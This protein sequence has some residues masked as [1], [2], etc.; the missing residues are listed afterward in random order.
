MG[1]PGVLDVVVW[2]VE[3]IRRAE[4]SDE[5][6]VPITSW[7]GMKPGEGGRMKCSSTTPVEPLWPTVHHREFRPTRSKTLLLPLHAHQMGSGQFSSMHVF[8]HTRND[9]G[10]R[11]KSR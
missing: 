4:H 5:M 8:L 3:E 6:A 1:E 10:S 7:E 9:T 11:V 2:I